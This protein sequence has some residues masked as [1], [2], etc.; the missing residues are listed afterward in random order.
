MSHGSPQQQGS[1]ALICK[2]KQLNFSEQLLELFKEL[3][4][5]SSFITFV[6]TL[7]IDHQTEH[8]MVQ[9][10]LHTIFKIMV[11]CSPNYLGLSTILSNNPIMDKIKW[12]SA[13]Q[14]A[15][16]GEL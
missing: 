7:G 8:K 2:T 9:T 10:G 11:Y 6:S 12:L 15:N 4:F 16:R 1:T 3:S 14:E 13:M 5:L